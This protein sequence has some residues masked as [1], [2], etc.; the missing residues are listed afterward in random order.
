VGGLFHIKPSVRCR[1][2]AHSVSCCAP[3]RYVRSW[4]K[5]GT[6]RVGSRSDPE[7]A[8]TARKRQ[9]GHAGHGPLCEDFAAV[10]ASA[11]DFKRC[12]HTVPRRRLR[13]RFGRAG[14]ERHRVPVGS[15]SERTV[16]D[17]VGAA[18]WIP[19]QPRARIR[20][21]KTCDFHI[22][23]RR[24][25]TLVLK[26]EAMTSSTDLPKRADL[27]SAVRTWIDDCVWPGD[28][29]SGNRRP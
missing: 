13:G 15:P 21:L 23:R 7:S 24:S 5:T 18:G 3:Q 26:I 9:R 19:R 16:R 4:G 8:P 6:R 10:S 29:A 12:L 20:S 25:L 14:R 28:Q 17:A 11:R 1:P 2:L 27:E 22:A